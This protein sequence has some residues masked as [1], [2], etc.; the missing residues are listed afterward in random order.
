[1]ESIHYF[2]HHPE[3]QDLFVKGLIDVFQM[4]PQTKWFFIRYWHGGPHIRVRFVDEVNI[5]EMLEQLMYNCL[6]HKEYQLTKEE[7]YKNHTFDGKEEDATKLPFYANGVYKKIKYEPE[8][9]R[10]GRGERLEFSEMAFQV[11]S[12]I[13]SRFFKLTLNRNA[14]LGLS[15]FMFHYFL[16]FIDNKNKFLDLYYQYWN[17]MNAGNMNINLSHDSLNILE[18]ILDNLKLGEVFEQELSRLTNLLISIQNSGIS[19]DAFNYIISS[20]IHMAN[21]RLSV[22]PQMEAIIAKLLLTKED[23]NVG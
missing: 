7:Y 5:K 19:N 6:E 17:Q 18:G 21:N 9:E 16:S 3:D 22:V 20:H 2:I 12:E 4:R 11:S 13:V 8:H 10:Y 15:I 1:M 14:K 23:T